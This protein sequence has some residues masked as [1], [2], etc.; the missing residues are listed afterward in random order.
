M[1][2]NM[3]VVGEIREYNCVRLVEG[4]ILVLLFV[5]WTSGSPSIDKFLLGSGEGLLLR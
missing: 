4:F 3:C 2:F 1:T 5:D